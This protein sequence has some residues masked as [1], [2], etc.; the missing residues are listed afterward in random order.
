MFA[1]VNKVGTD[2]AAFI[3]T[4]PKLQAG[5]NTNS[6]VMATLSGLASL[7][8]QVISGITIDKKDLKEAMANLAFNY[9][10]PG[11]AWAEENGNDEIFKKLNI[12]KSKILKAEDGLAGPIVQNMYDILNTN[13]A[14]LIPFGLTAAMLGQILASINDYTA[15]VPLT[16][17][18]VNNRQT[19]TT[20]IEKL[21]KKHL[22]FLERQLDSLVAPHFN[23]QPDFVSTY[24]NSREIIDPP[25][26]ST[27]FKILVLE[28]SPSLLAAPAPVPTPVPIVNAKAQAVGAAKF[29]FTDETGNCELKGFPKGIYSILVTSPNHT[30]VQQDNISIGLGQ[31]KSLTFTLLPL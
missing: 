21:I 14:T 19:Y 22:K 6:A 11:R 18:A 25:T 10:G 2:N 7:Q 15:Q 12:S 5:F 31:T 13:A 9:S 23:T 28:Q 8:A 20:N 27:T 29:A 16:T 1:S 30:P 26:Q 24:T 3:N 4:I 17:A